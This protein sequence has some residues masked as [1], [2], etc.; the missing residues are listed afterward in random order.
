MKQVIII[1]VTGLV[2][3]LGGGAGIAV[4]RAP[5]G[6]AGASH[7]VAD[8][9]VGV[10]A[11]ETGITPDGPGNAASSPTDSDDAPAG[12]YRDAEPAPR[13]ADGAPVTAAQVA[14]R[15][16]AGDVPTA[17]AESSVADSAAAVQLRRISRTFANMSPREAAKVLEL[18]EDADVNAILGSLNEK[19]GAVILAAFPPARAAAI[20]RQRLNAARMR[21]P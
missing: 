4:M 20:S 8:S 5:K 14:Q 2:A 6:V 13:A 12:N 21:T 1:A 15:S 10:A 19:Q 7:A 3:G 16:A 18:M 11:N 9:T 17:L